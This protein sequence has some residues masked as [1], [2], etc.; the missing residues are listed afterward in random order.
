MSDL[1]EICVIF[2]DQRKLYVV[3]KKDNIEIVK[4]KIKEE[5][6]IKEREIKL[7]EIRRNAE[8]ISVLSFK[9]ERDVEILLVDEPKSSQNENTNNVG[10]IL[11]SKEQKNGSEIEIDYAKLF[12]RKFASNQMIIDLNTWALPLK[13]KLISL[14]VFSISIR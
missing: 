7:L 14:E 2:N 13:F 5:F 8:I 6:S 1:V 9:E 10:N 4:Q 11:I 12:G 3:D